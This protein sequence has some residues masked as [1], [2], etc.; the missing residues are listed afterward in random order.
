MSQE[1]RESFTEALSNPQDYQEDMGPPDRIACLATISFTDEK[2]YANVEAH[3]LPIH[4][5]WIFWNKFVYCVMVNNGST[6]NIIP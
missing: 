2:K 5:L 6:V 4:T 1:L 3:N